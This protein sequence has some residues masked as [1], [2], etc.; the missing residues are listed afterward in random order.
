MRPIQN[1]SILQFRSVRTMPIQNRQTCVACFSSLKVHQT[2]LDYTGNQT[3]IVRVEDEHTDRLTTA[4]LIL[5]FP[6]ETLR[7]SELLPTKIT[8]YCKDIFK[9]FWTFCAKSFLYTLLLFVN[10]QSLVFCFR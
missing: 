10:R 3:Q 8:A 1:C 2:P 4:T 5:A 6:L 9:S 7:G